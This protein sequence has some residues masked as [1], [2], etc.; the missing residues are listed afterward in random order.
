[1]FIFPQTLTAELFL[2]SSIHYVSTAYK[3]YNKVYKTSKDLLSKNEKVLDT[4]K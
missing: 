3:L 1:M 4:K 2:I